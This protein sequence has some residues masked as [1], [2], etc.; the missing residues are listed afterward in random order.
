MT[1]WRNRI[2]RYSEEAPDQLVANP[3]NW[4]THPG[5]Q[6]EALVGVL[7]DVGWVQNVIVSARSGFLVDGHLRVMEALKAGQPTIPVTWVDLS[8]EEEA[9]ILSTLDPLS[10]MAGVDSAAL[11]TL[12]RDVATDSPAVAAMLDALAQEAGI[13]PP[14]VTF[15]EYDE[16]V[17]DEVQYCECPS[18][19][20]KFPK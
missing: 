2:T 15:K 16:S 18:C 3:A 12:L 5:S 11:D 9:L 7:A 19:G 6:A 1:V 10:A 14:D 4:R 13:T 17:A 8:P 20:H